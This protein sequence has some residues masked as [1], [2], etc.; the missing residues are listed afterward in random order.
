V[1]VCPTGIDIRHGLQYECIGCAGCVD[2]CDGVMDKMNYPRGLIRFTTQNA[3]A[4][5]WTPAAMWRRV[6][7]PRVLLY[8]AVLSMLCL[9]LGWSLA[10][11]TPLKVDVVRDRGA[12]SRIVAGGRLEN[13]YRL[14]IMNATEQ[15]QRYRI[16]ASGLAGLLVASEPEV[17][18]GPAESR[19]VA[20][21]LQIPYGSVPSGS[22]PIHFEV[23]SLAA[24]AHVSERS[25]FLVPRQESP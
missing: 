11:R 9:G 25:V 10:M 4:Q 19:W 17:G 6:L 5:G 12:L 14:Q 15:P 7:R 2:V 1:Q 13:V 3:M 20:V 22:H 18:V 16:E 21:R 23:G 8:L 24:G